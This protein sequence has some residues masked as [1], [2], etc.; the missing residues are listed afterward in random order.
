MS[1]GWVDREAVCVS[2]TALDTPREFPEGRR[3]ERGGQTGA[4]SGC[5]EGWGTSEGAGGKVIP[6]VWAGAAARV[7]G[8]AAV[9]PP[10]MGIG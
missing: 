7:T 9:L 5:W 2:R 1:L 3:A 6:C 8:L 10:L 4:K